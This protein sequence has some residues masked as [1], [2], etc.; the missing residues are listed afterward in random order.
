MRRTN[1]IERRY[2]N[3][4]ER[5][6]DKILRICGV[7]AKNKEDKQDLVQ[8]VFLNIWKSLPS[9]QGKSSMDTWLYR[10]TLNVCLRSRYVKNRKKVSDLESVSI[11]PPV[12]STK[13]EKYEELYDCISKLPDTDRSLI[14]LYLED[15]PYK[16]IANIIGITEN[17]VAVKLKRIRKSLLNCLKKS[18]YER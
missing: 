6:K 18:G 1:E 4:L 13:E 12:V 11:I 2:I 8:D 5:N 10:I 14:I 9:Y 16:E 3:I 17:H 15:L 7:Y